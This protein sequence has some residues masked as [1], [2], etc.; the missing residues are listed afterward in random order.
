[1]IKSSNYR[2]FLSEEYENRA[3]KNSS[4]TLSAFSRDINLSV[5][6]L[7]AI[8]LKKCGLSKKAAMNIS[9]KLRFDQYK[10]EIF[11]DMVEAEHSR[12]HVQRS[13]AKSRLASKLNSRSH[14]LQLEIF[15]T[16]SDWYHFAILELISVK[17]FKQNPKWMARRLGISV[18]EVEAATQRLFK[19]GILTEENGQW[20]ASQQFIAVSPGVPSEA[21]R[22]YHEQMLQKA[23]AAIHSQPTD[24]RDLGSATLSF[25]PQELP[26]ARQHLEEFRNEFARKFRGSD[27]RTALYALT[28]QFF[29]LDNP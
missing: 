18:K 5:S 20:K 2:D 29:Q 10:E 8:L 23:Q 11:L 4:Y 28:V 15:K 3:K 14:E 26:E 17:G 9:K 12:S 6:H 1:M 22:I 13:I 25:N 21:V 19:V 27:D 7:S 24:K 16:I